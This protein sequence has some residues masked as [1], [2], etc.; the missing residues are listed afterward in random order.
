MRSVSVLMYTS[1]FPKLI[2]DTTVHRRCVW[3]CGSGKKRE[4]ECKEASMNWPLLGDCHALWPSTA[5]KSCYHFYSFVY[6][7]SLHLSS[8]NSYKGELACFHYIT[9]CELK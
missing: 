2:P 6:K 7:Q 8:E 4:N 3:H 1:A 9:L 5:V